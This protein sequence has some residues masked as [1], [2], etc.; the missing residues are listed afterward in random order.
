MVILLDIHS[1]LRWII[2][3]VGFIA[4]AKFLI[5]WAR[6]SAFGKMDR[7]LS[8]GFSGLMDLQVTLGLLYFFITG[9]AGMGFPMFRIEHM[10][11]ML[12]AAAAGH[13]PSFF[14]KVG[15]KFVVALGAIVVALLLVYVGVMR[16]PGGWNR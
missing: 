8:S 12:L 3:I 13:A 6:K 11:T 2:V 5:G 15:N 1:I 16:L 4:I 9:F 14:K 7:G 10:V